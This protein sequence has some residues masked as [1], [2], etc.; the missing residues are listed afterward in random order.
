MPPTDVSTT[1][2]A[3][4]QTQGNS[5]HRAPT[6]SSRRASQES[7]PAP[8]TPELL[9]G[10]SVDERIRLRAYHLYEHRGRI[11]GQALNDWLDAERELRGH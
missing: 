3:R 8:Q 11:D 4:A 9:A 1:A 2:S 5:G 7:L 10:P 6:R